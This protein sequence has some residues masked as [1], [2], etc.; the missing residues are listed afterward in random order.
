MDK[1]KFFEA[2]Y[3]FIREEIKE[4]KARIFRLAGFGLVG[5]PTAYTFATK[6]DIEIIAYVLPFLICALALI[7][8]AESQ[9]LMRAGRY[10]RCCIEPIYFPP[11]TA[12]HKDTSCEFSLNIGWETWLEAQEKGEPGRR[13]GDKLIALFFY[14]LFFLY[15]LASVWLASSVAKSNLGTLGQSIVLGFYVGL[16]VVFGAIL[17]MNFARSTSTCA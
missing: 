3:V 4:I 16:G 13:S 1:D 9:A 11:S 10:I 15:Y 7:F 8:M 14:S 2:Q 6:Y 5:V 17:F 12:E